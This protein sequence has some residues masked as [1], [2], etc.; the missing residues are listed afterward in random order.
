MARIPEQAGG[1]A[2]NQQACLWMNNQYLNR[3]I[4]NWGMDVTILSM[5]AP[6]LS[7]FLRMLVCFSTRP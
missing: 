7:H 1:R 5:N 3:N 2:S 6:I 4:K